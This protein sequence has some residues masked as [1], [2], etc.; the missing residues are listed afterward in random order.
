M[1]QPRLPSL[2][3]QATWLFAAKILGFALSFILPL[4][5]VRTLPVDDFGLYRQAFV[6][7]MTLSS[8]LP[9]G[10][11]VSA[12]YFLARNEEQRPSA[13][14]N[15]LLFFSFTGGSVFL[16]LA[17]FPQLLALIFANPE[18]E[19]LSMLIGLLT[20][21]WI[22]S[23]F[24]DSIAFAN[25]EPKIGAI[26][27][28]GSQLTR[29]IAVLVAIAIY[30]SVYSI[31]VASIIQAAL[32]TV[33]LFLY[34]ESRFPGFWWKFDAGFFKEHI[35]YSLPYGFI[36]LTWNFHLNLHY[37]F[38]GYHFS[39]A[40]FA[41]YAVG[42]FQLPLIGMLSES[43]NSVLI[44]RMSELQMEDNR[45]EMIRLVARATQRL[46]MVYFPAFV[47]LFI[48]AEELITLLFTETYVEST[49]IF[50]I[51]ILV[52]PFGALISDSIVRSYVE[53]GQFM[54]RLR[55]FSAIVLICGLYLAAASASLL[56][57]VSVMV[58]V[59]LAEM[60]V[61]EVS[62]FWKI[63]FKRDDLRLFKG[64]VAVAICSLAAGIVGNFAYV[65]SRLYLPTLLSGTFGFLEASET[66]P[67]STGLVSKI[68]ILAISFFAF[69]SI[70]FLLILKFGAIT[71]DEKLL[72]MRLVSL[73][74]WRDK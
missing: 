2:S 55:I 49:P 42:C 72:V 8:I 14:L 48:C 21:V 26:F 51:F 5:V 44:P 61:A 38:V 31:L 12:F 22:Y 37:F 15:I 34:A 45:R 73:R 11:G 10:L 30:E 24:L 7:V 70:Y 74:R 17:A 59:R 23:L 1:V 68:S 56:A 67:A 13:I 4:V 40:Q 27:V 62:I 71:P 29:T 32:Q 33:V 25:R 3:N 58:F 66:F 19:G 6:V 36:G 54:L 39:A 41:V 57:I 65:I 69:V 16:I 35:R 53:L 50:R 43:V 20:L 18:M 60:I 47:F 46:A 52:L 64:I 63:G 28:V 9:F